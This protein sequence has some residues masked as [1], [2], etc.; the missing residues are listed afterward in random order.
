MTEEIQYAKHQ[1]EKEDGNRNED[2]I[3]KVGGMGII[4]TINGKYGVQQPEASKFKDSHIS[5]A[6][7]TIKGN[8]PKRNSLPQMEKSIRLDHFQA[9]EDSDSMSDSDYSI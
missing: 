5:K 3:F 9:M 7:I 6:L 4:T 2:N 1:K 8:K